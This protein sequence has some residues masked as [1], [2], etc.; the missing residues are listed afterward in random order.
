MLGPRETRL[1]E[2]GT[3]TIFDVPV[4][5]EAVDTRSGEAQVYDL[6]RLQKWLATA[7]E[8]QDQEGYEAPIR[9]GHDDPRTGPPP[10][11][12][13]FAL[14]RIGEVS[15][16]GAERACLFADLTVFP[17]VFDQIQ[18]G[19]LPYRSP[20]IKPDLSEFRS[21]DLLSADAPFH[22]FEL[23]RV[24]EPQGA[25][26][27]TF[28][29]GVGYA[30]RGAPMSASNLTPATT[31]LL[32]AGAPPAKPALKAFADTPLAGPPAAPGAPGAPAPS[33]P[34]AD[35]KTKADADAMLGG[36][37]KG[38]ADMLKAVAEKLGVMG[39]KPKDDAP[40]AEDDQTPKPAAPVE[41]PAPAMSDAGN[42]TLAALRGEL[43]ALRNRVE[44]GEKTKR[45]DDAEN[46]M[47]SHG[48]TPE[49]VLA[50][51]DLSKTSDVA[52]VAFADALVKA[53]PRQPIDPP[54]WTG[55]LDPRGSLED[56]PAEVKAF[57]DRGP[58]IMGQA[59][60]IARNHAKLVAG[61]HAAHTLAETLAANLP[62]A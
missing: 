17:E 19:R 51:R 32:A 10:L 48:A 11:A 16:D 46:R 28:A 5:A 62:K 54:A 24:Q 13:R 14:T 22:K 31:A 9:I 29:D 60:R 61:G 25:L 47:R 37:L 30:I 33:A 15:L 50:F 49:N 59:R 55:E 4:F 7:R 45:L 58:V 41:I 38:I 53:A 35:D 23:L 26:A 2:D 52:A 43:A 27:L 40:K 18:A 39:E 21:V 12:G 34:P 44:A 36:M 42:V 6:A 3:V 1:N 56:D 8:R 20:T 57:A